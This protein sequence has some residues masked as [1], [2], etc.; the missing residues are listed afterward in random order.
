MKRLVLA[1]S[2]VLLTVV[3]GGAVAQAYFLDAPHNESNGIYCYTCHSM[4]YWR[5]PPT[6]GVDVTTRNAVCLQCHLEGS[7]DP[8]R[9]PA[10]KPHASSTTS[11]EKGVWSTECTQCHD[12]HTQ[13]QLDWA[14]DDG[15]LLFLA[16]GSLT[17]GG[18]YLASDPVDSPNYGS[19]SFSISGVD[20]QE[21]W[22]DPASWVA[23]GGK[24]DRARAV[25]DSRGLIFVPDRDNPN[26]AYEIIAASP[27]S[28]KVKGKITTTGLAGKTF[29][30]IYGQ[31]IKSII[32]PNGG[33][34]VRDYRDVKFFKPEVIAGSAGGYIDLGGSEKPMG[35]CQV[36]HNGTSYWTK[37]G[38]NIGHNT[39]TSC[40]VCHDA[41]KGLAGSADHTGFIGDR[42][43]TGCGTCH[44]KQVAAPETGHR[45]GCNACHANPKPAINNNV[46][47]KEGGVKVRDALTGNYAS[48]GYT[49]SFVP[50]D[51]PRLA[52]N[53]G[54]KIKDSGFVVVD[55]SECHELKRAAYLA[56]NHGHGPT[57]F[58]WDSNCADCH[59]TD[60]L[61]VAKGV[62]VGVHKN[63]CALCHDVGDYTVR[64]AGNSTNGV[65][66][67]A[68]GATRLSECTD[69]HNTKYWSGAS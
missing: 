9:G 21:G 30:V 53:Q 32:M 42:L 2:Y 7:V 57:T 23:K 47:T 45:G 35:L 17:S 56:G 67:T 63:N 13:P 12:A 37:D 50:V 40:G 59:G 10:K 54:R 26:E 34:T 18:A 31:S 22:G 16:W 19:T 33:R 65:D 8:R 61:E 6:G 44:P 66:G 1:V 46:L 55:C 27:T 11:T 3:C 36:C 49:Y 20:G 48:T 64:I 62:A 15:D 52:D 39:E 41:L 4:S 51:A 25:D 43:N 58:G 68:V 14:A 60:P 24:I 5:T 38:N 29:G 28:I 69:C